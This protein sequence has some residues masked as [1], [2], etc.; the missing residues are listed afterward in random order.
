MKSLILLYILFTSFIGFSQKT[1]KTYIQDV[2]YQYV[3]GDFNSAKVYLEKALENYPN[4]KELYKLKGLIE[5]DGGLVVEIPKPKNEGNSVKGKG[6]GGKIESGGNSGGNS[7]GGDISQK[8]RV[9]PDPD[10]DGFI[11]IKD[12]CSN[13]FGKIEG[14]PDSDSDG[15]PDYRDN[16]PGVPGGGSKNGCPVPKSITISVD[17]Q[18][19]T[20]NLFSW[21][22]ALANE[23]LKTTIIFETK[24]G[25]TFQ[26]DVTGVSSFKFKTGDTRFDGVFTNVKLIIESRQGVKII[27]TKE[28]KVKTTC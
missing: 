18:M 27:G 22:S 7:S 2:K 23:G 16:C 25:S 15:V 1:E 8:P 28:I 12:K 26:K 19:T 17:L 4:S 24:S 14:C 20:Q 11:G 5:E 9:D 6:E 3:K 13:E 10:G 21:N